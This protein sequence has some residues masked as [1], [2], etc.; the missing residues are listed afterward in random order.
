MS[1][2]LQ[3]IVVTPLSHTQFYL[4][5]RA[6]AKSMK[7]TLS[8][9]VELNFWTSRHQQFHDFGHMGYC[10]MLVLITSVLTY[11]F[12]ATIGSHSIDDIFSS[13]LLS[14]VLCQVFQENYILKIGSGLASRNEYMN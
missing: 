10:V 6:I 2:H 11:F 9:G 14:C 5:V 3:S 7:V 8:F 13:P 4:M 1:T 12:V